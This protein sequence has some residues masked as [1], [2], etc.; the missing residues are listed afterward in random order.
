MA[1]ERVE[2]NFEVEDE[3]EEQTAPAP[4][5]EVEAPEKDEI[6]EMIDRYMGAQATEEAPAQGSSE[7]KPF[8]QLS[9]QQQNQM[10]QQTGMSRDQLREYVNENI[11]ND[12]FSTTEKMWNQTFAPQV[13]AS[14]KP[15]YEGF[16]EVSK[17]RVKNDEQL[18]PVWKKYKGEVEAEVK[19]MPQADRFRDP[20]NVY[21]EAAVKVKGRHSEEIGRE[22][23]EA[24][25]R[26]MLEELL[27]ERDGK[28]GGS[29]SSSSRAPNYAETNGAPVSAGSNGEAEGPK[30]RTVRMSR[31]LKRELEVEAR[32]KGMSFEKYAD[33]QYRVNPG[34]FGK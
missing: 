9:P 23:T 27:A 19:K 18:A 7:D 22:N 30:K 13:A 21:R 31:G 24:T 12:A 20:L 10:Q 8:D 16:V 17:D 3:G 26:K 14:I 32:K 4:A 34:R 1:D 25:M 29:G 15:L 2:M 6:Q 11:L 33:V 5:H 28:K